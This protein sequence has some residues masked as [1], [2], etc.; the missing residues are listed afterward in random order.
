MESL[1]LKLI[2]ALLPTSLTI[3]YGAVFFPHMDYVEYLGGS[4]N[5]ILTFVVLVLL[6]IISIAVA[7][8]PNSEDGLKICLIFTALL[9]VIVPFRGCAIMQ[10]FDPVNDISVELVE[11]STDRSYSRYTISLKLSFATNEVDELYGGKGE[12]HFYDGDVLVAKQ[13]ISFK[14][15]NNNRHTYYSYSFDEY[16]PAIYGID[17]SSLQIYCSI[18]TVRFSDDLTNEHTYTP[19]T[20]RIK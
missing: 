17:E 7:C 8:I 2:S 15:I 19:M 20:V 1:I 14:K 3:F 11:Y 16:T 18:D 10:D 12:L 13:P 9:F 5:V 6:S 4:A